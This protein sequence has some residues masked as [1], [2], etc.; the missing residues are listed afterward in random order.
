MRSRVALVLLLVAALFQSGFDCSG[1]PASMTFN[2]E[3]ESG[4]VST[5]SFP[6]QVTVQAGAFQT[7]T[8]QFTLNGQPLAMSGGP[9]VF[10]TTQN[11]GAPLLDT[12]VLEVSGTASN[13]VQVVVQRTFQYAP[14]K[15]RVRQITSASDLLGGPIAH[16]R[17]GDY[18][19][20][21]SAAR[22]IVQDVAQRD[23]HS[24]GMYGGNIIDAEVVG[25]PDKDNFFEVQPS[26]NVETVINAQTVQ[27]LNDGQNGLPAQLRTCGPDDTMDYINPSAVAEQ[28]GAVFPASANDVDYQVE[29]CTV[30]TLEPYKTF[31]KMETTVTNLENVA[32]GFYVGD[33][34]NG[35]GELEQ[36]TDPLGI[37]EVSTATMNGLAYIGFGEAQG[38]DYGFTGIPFSGSFFPSYTFFT[39]SGV[40]F[41]MASHS[42]PLV[43]FLSQPPTFQVAA[44]GS[45][46]Y[47][48]YFSVGDGSGGNTIDVANEV[49]AVAKGT[50]SGCVTAGG[51]PAPG[52]RV[53]VGAISGSAL[54]SVVSTWVADANGCYAGSVPTGSYGV[55]GS[56]TGY[57][58]EGGGTLPLIHPVTI[59]SGGASVQDIALP[60]TGRLQVSIVDEAGAAVPGRVTIVGF[61]PSPEPT[62]VFPGGFG[63][64]N[65]VNGTFHDV[66]KDGLPFGTARVEYTPADGTLDIPL[67]PGSYQI[68]VS[69][70]TEY[71]AYSAPITLTAGNVTNVAAQ[72]AR[73]IDTPGFISSDF[74]VHAIN[75]PDSRINYTR[76]VRSFGGEGV[77]NLILTEHD[78]HYDL[79][80][81]VAAEGF[82]PF[83]KST[84]GEEITTFDYGHF[85]A[86]PL[87]VDPSRPSGG[88]TDHGGAAPPGQDFVQY[89]N[90]SLS[91]AQIYAAA[92]GGSTSTPDTV[93]QVNHIDSHFSPLRINTK[94]TPPQS[95]LTAAQKLALRQDPGIANLFHHFP[96]LE[97]WNGNNRGDQGQF[98]N[99]RI[100][101]WFNHLNQGL[102]T[103]MIGD[104]D[105]HTLFDTNGGGARTWTAS[106]TDAP[107]AIS[108]ADMADAVRTGRAVAGQGIYVQTRLLA[109]S[110]GG[111]A[112]FTKTGSTG[113]ATTDGTAQLEIRVQAPTWAEYDRIEIYANAATTT[114]A[115][116]GGVPVLFGAVPTLVLSKNVDFTVSTVA[117]HPSVP[118]AQRFETL[119]T[120]SFAGLTQDTWFVVVVKGTD[121][122]SRPMFP[123]FPAS[124]RTT[125]NTTLANLLDG[126]LG[127]NGTLALGN[128][129]A[130][131]LDVDGGGWTPPGVQ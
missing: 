126:N 50:L 33:Y 76:R 31:V 26:I 69:R 17:I 7:G 110:T 42:I 29:G 35:M 51:Q 55:V 105:T 95:V 106:A 90:Y 9:L 21:N 5:F 62:I 22:F 119:K 128:T 72:I 63:L 127:E 28:V 123:V 34:I 10:S 57:P 129:N 85:N 125:G 65:A 25:V 101:V 3:I 6:I 71:S 53:S 102:R 79:T 115:S 60:A 114:A 67:E 11:P 23:M 32:R 88:S 80:A 113:T 89:G 112:D 43:L 19:M 104:T 12:N 15:A 75:S 48:R 109:P 59:T 27:I 54:S 84:I 96:A 92:T 56:L 81:K 108:D 39:T 58:Y 73:V 120:V 103:T 41:V 2:P 66:S 124:L 100:G 61:D 118:T 44:N 47:V 117:P 107:A 20:E 14:P 86:Y 1:P 40:S 83:V 68:T 93:V 97:L 38:V 52:A 13:G 16:G 130:L 121:G 36:W 8:L 77:E 64:P 111:V 98:L 87:L 74:H 70:G 4:V 82:T 45:K 91:P 30:Y 131:Y 78:A 18:R 46:S 94:L 99:Q 116:N 122:V 49:K 24:I 37:G